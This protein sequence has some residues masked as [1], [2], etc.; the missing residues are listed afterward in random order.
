M[1]GKVKRAPWSSAYALGLA[2]PRR[3]QG[4]GGIR[5]SLHDHRPLPKQA[6]YSDRVQGQDYVCR[7]GVS[8]ADDAGLSLMDLDGRMSISTECQ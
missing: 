1:K 5:R 3:V 2:L 6:R 8:A 4:S 7:S